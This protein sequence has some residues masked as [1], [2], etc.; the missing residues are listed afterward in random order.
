MVIKAGAEDCVPMCLPLGIRK[1]PFLSQPHKRPWAFAA[2][3]QESRAEAFELC[4]ADGPSVPMSGA[5]LG[6]SFI[7]PHKFLP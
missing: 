3:Q 1:D 4:E 2:A 6:L 7:P 5:V